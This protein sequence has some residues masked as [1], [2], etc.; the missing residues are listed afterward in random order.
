MC[1]FS[2]FKASRAHEFVRRLALAF[3]SNKMLRALSARLEHRGAA[4]E[5]ALLGE[6]LVLQWRAPALPA[7]GGLHGM[8]NTGSAAM[9]QPAVTMTAR[10]N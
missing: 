1:P 8:Q 7:W 5:A 10:R 9:A 6:G 3:I 2:K 4:A